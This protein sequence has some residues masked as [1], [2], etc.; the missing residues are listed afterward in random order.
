MSGSRFSRS[1]RRRIGLL[2]YERN[3]W[4]IGVHVRRPVVLFSFLSPLLPSLPIHSSFRFVLERLNRP[5]FG[6]WMFAK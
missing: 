4:R 3:K 6:V 2:S 1:Y 5:S